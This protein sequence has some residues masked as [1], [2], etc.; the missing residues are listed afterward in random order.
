MKEQHLK[1]VIGSLSAYPNSVP[2]SPTS[3]VPKFSNTTSLTIQAAKYQDDK[4]SALY[5]E[6]VQPAIRPKFGTIVVVKPKLESST[7]TSSEAD[8]KYLAR[9]ISFSYFRTSYKVEIMA[10]GE[11]KSVRVKM[12][13]PSSGSKKE[14]CGPAGSRQRDD[15]TVLKS[16]V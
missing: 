2:P 4:G 15:S 3:G 13:F 9:I 10:T 16:K 12:L 8:A 14:D 7:S 6:A 1:I 11:R 5:A